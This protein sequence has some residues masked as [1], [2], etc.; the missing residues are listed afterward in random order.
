MKP[1]VLITAREV[2]EILSQGLEH[3]GYKIVHLPE[4]DEEALLKVI[5][6]YEGIIITTYTK[7][8]QKVLAHAH[9]LRFIGRVGSGLENVDILAAQEKGIRVF[10]SPEGNANAVGEHT[11]GLLLNLMNHISTAH[12]EVKNGIWQREKNRG[13]ELD[14]KTVGIIGLGH[15]GSAFAKKLRG[16]DVQVLAYDKFKVDYGNEWIKESSLTDLLRQSDVI[17]VHIPYSSDNYHFINKGVFAQIQ[18]SPYLLMACRGEV[19]NTIDTLDVIRAGKLRGLGIDVFEDEPWM[20]SNKVPAE[21]Y[22]E[23]LASDKVVATPHIAG[24]TR[25]SKVLLAQILLDKI[26]TWKSENL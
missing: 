8:N 3:L 24:W 15:T 5:S 23:L 4:P 18:K 13:E 11:L 17:S 16:F 10:N 25:E 7:V 1:K 14:G 12:Q 20:Q 21:V 6:D 2:D 19:L 9:A 22:R 26:A